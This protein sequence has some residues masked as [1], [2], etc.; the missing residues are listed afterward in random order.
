[1][2]PVKVILS[3]LNSRDDSY[4]AQRQSG[5]MI[6]LLNATCMLAAQNMELEASVVS[7]WYRRLWIPAEDSVCVG[8]LKKVGSDVS[9]GQQQHRCAHQQRANAGLSSQTSVSLGA[10]NR[11]RLLLEVSVFQDSS[12]KY[13]LGSTQR[14]IS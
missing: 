3:Q 1:M 2:S 6:D 11:R 4:F 5:P 10:T 13:S 8:R 12:R 9:E 14:R 7:I